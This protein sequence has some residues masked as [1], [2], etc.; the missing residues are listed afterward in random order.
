[1]CLYVNRPKTRPQ[2]KKQWAR[3]IGEVGGGVR[4]HGATKNFFV[5]WYHNPKIQRHSRTKRGRK[6]RD[7][8]KKRRKVA[9][10]TVFM[11]VTNKIAMNAI[12]WEP[13]R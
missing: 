7:I 9:N 2:A 11:E 3:P 6:G 10:G 1:M 12:N 5:V 8:K 13:R 4:G